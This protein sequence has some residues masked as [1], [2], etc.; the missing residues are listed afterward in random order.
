MLIHSR[1]LLELLAPAD[2]SRCC[3]QLDV[4][5]LPLKLHTFPSG[6]KVLQLRNQDAAGTAAEIRAACEQRGPIGALELSRLRR[7]PLLLA[8]QLLL[9]AEKR[10]LL[11]RDDTLQGLLF[12]PNRFLRP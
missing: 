5:A 4:L 7:A 2:L 10:G 8:E 11:C 9:D 12:Y 3:D 1:R 6:V